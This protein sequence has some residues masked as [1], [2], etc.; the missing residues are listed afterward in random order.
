[1]PTFHTVKEAAKLTGKSPSSIRRIIHPIVQTDQHPDRKHVSPT[2]EEAHNLR[3]KGINFAWRISDELLHRVIPP[4]SDTGEG[5]DTSPK[6]AQLH[7]TVDLLAT[8]R[9]ELD[10]KNQQIENQFK[11]LSQYAELMKGL[12]ERLREGNVLIASLQKQLSPPESDKSLTT[13]AIDAST[14]PSR[15]EDSP[16]KKKSPI[17]AAKRK[18]GFLDW[19]R[20]R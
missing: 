11:Q 3:E 7:G 16:A 15:A 10:I 1:M 17:K 12:S 6:H 8:L 14:Q 9:K 4:Q 18:R 2:V 20:R 5:T 13:T 19:F